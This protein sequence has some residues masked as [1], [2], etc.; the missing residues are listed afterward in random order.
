M[1]NF[2]TFLFIV[3]LILLS[4]SCFSQRTDVLQLKNGNRITGE[5]KK[6][7]YGLL[8]YKTDDIG[9]LE[10]EW[11]DVMKL[12]SKQTFELTL[13]THDTYNG[14]L[15]STSNSGE[16]VLVVNSERILLS[17][18]E[19]VKIFQLK[20][21]FFSRLDGAVSAG[22]NFSKSSNVSKINLNGNVA[23]NTFNR[24]I[25]LSGS[26]E[27]TEQKIQDTTTELTE[28]QSFTLNY[29]RYFTDRWFVGT[30]AGYEKN[31]G[32]GLDSRIKF[33][34]GGGKEL[35]Q[36]NFHATSTFIGLSA[37]TE[38][39]TEGISRENLEATGLIQYRIYKYAIPKIILSTD[40]AGYASLNE[41]DR[42]RFNAD[43]KV[44][45]EFLKD[46]ILSIAYFYDF[47]NKPATVGASTFDWGVTTTVGYTF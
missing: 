2:A 19:L 35:F 39:P 44:D 20:K 34:A 26:T 31:T 42:Y 45:F 28:K 30:L 47:D 3:F 4:T 17:M 25:S 24:R 22:F 1:K 40:F 7:E 10:V 16:I 13:S 33:G 37:N 6:L 29:Y 11:K 18:E 43:I 32:L 15:D 23:H 14:S 8:T 27:L 36:N 46:F 12:T 41:R 38:T 5:I 21:T 9:T